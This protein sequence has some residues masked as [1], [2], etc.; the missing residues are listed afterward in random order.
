[1]EFMARV[2]VKFITSWRMETIRNVIIRTVQ[3]VELALVKVYMGAIETKDI[4]IG[5]RHRDPPLS[6]S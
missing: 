2:L 5:S 3:V 1:M 4:R 6:Y